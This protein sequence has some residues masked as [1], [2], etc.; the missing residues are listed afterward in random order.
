MEPPCAPLP[1]LGAGGF[2]YRGTAFCGWQRQS[3]SRRYSGR[4]NWRCHRSRRPRPPSS[5]RAA[6]DTG[7]HASLQVVH[8]DTTAAR[9]PTA[10]V[11]GGNQF[12]PDDVAIRWAAPG[13]TSSSMR[14][15]RHA[16]RRCVYL[17]TSALQRPGCMP[18]R[19]RLDALAA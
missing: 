3:R 9:E 15:S 7:V 10:W 16:S 11:R 5:P 1:A 8:F 17:L 14:A 18:G 6:P 13:R 19:V 2:E 12:L 4:S